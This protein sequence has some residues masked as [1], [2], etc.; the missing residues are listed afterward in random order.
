MEVLLR[1]EGGEGYEAAAA[2]R[3]ADLG[4]YVV[5]TPLCDI[6]SSVLRQFTLKSGRGDLLRDV[7]V[8][9]IDALAREDGAGGGVVSL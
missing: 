2:A 4:R 1:Y 5:L 6:L 8:P 3:K 9:L 7:R